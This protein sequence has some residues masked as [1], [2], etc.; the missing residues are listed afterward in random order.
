[1]NISLIKEEKELKESISFLRIG[2]DW[3]KNKACKVVKSIISN[4]RNLGIYGYVLKSNSNKI[5]GVI[6]IF[7]QGFIND[8]KMINISSWYVKPKYRGYYSLSM[9]EKLLNDFQNFIITDLT[10]TKSVYKILKSLDLKMQKLIM[11]NTVL[12]QF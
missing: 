3:S 8:F 5:M 11:K 10:P 1:M 6:L 4:N 12:L 9:I 2:M 7:D